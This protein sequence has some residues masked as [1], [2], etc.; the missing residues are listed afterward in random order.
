MTLPLDGKSMAEFQDSWKIGSVLKFCFGKTWWTVIVHSGTSNIWKN[1]SCEEWKSLHKMFLCYCKQ[2]LQDAFW[3][4]S[5]PAV[6]LNICFLCPCRWWIKHAGK[7]RQHP[8]EPG[9]KHA[10]GAHEGIVFVEMLAQPIAILSTLF[11]KDVFH[12]LLSSVLGQLGRQQVFW[13][14]CCLICLSHG[15]SSMLWGCTLLTS[16][17]GA[18]KEEPDLEQMMGCCGRY[19]SSLLSRGDRPGHESWRAVRWQ[20]PPI[21]DQQCA[22]LFLSAFTFGRATLLYRHCTVLVTAAEKP[23]I[24]SRVTKGTWNMFI[25]FCF[26][27]FQ[28]MN[29][30]LCVARQ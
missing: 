14:L 27:S 13:A 9:E 6:V 11:L 4:N 2:I 19:C 23:Y 25:L 21:H 26:H 20:P 17:C 22:C 8:G 28:I 30:C 29:V 1:L 3:Q 16:K 7:I 24:V 15:G 5:A 18:L 12:I 10:S